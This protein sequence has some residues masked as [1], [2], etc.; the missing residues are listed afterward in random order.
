MDSAGMRG[1]RGRS[2][3]GRDLLLGLVE[4]IRRVNSLGF[5]GL[6]LRVYL[7]PKSM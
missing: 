1:L 2:G 5:R 6:G 4:S 3:G 7:D